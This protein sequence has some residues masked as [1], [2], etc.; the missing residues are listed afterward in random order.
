MPLGNHA[1]DG[2]AQTAPGAHA[3]AF[4]STAIEAVENALTLIGWYA[5]TAI[6]HNEEGMTTLAAARHIDLPACRRIAQCIVDQVVE[7]NAQGFGIAGDH[8]SL[9]DLCGT[10][11]NRLGLGE[12]LVG[13]N[14]AANQFGKTHRRKAVFGSTWLLPR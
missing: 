9:I 3:I 7:Q 5:L 1:H 4:A 6:G 10:E 2:Q 8:R 11:V 14:R 12:T 13:N